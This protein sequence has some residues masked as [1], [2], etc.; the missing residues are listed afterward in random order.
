LRLQSFPNS[1]YVEFARRDRT[2][3]TGLPI[4]FSS[5]AFPGVSATAFGPDED[6][7]S[8]II[9]AGVGTQWTPR[10]AT[11]V[12]YQEQLGRDNYDANGVTGT[13]SFSF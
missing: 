3:K 6:H 9:N 12:G 2:G 11:Y 8:A 13:I 5:A 4:T 7:D 10:I 1:S